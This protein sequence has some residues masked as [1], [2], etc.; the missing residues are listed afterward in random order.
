LV[1]AGKLKLIKQRRK[2]KML[3]LFSETETAGIHKKMKKKI[4]HPEPP[5]NYIEDLDQRIN[6]IEAG[7]AEYVSWEQ[8]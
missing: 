3:I 8:I 1:N 6:E 4:A 5:E 2:M 7:T